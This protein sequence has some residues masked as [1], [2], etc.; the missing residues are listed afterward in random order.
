MRK[1]LKRIILWALA[2]DPAP[3]YDPATLDRIASGR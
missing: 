3:E 1:I 2:A